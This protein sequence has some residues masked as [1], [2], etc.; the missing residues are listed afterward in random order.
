LPKVYIDARW[1]VRALSNLLVNAHK[2]TSDSSTITLRGYI[3]TTE[4]TLMLEVSDD[5]PGIPLESQPRLFDRFYRV[6]SIEQMVPGTGLGLAIVKSVADL[7]GGKIVVKSAPGEGSCFQMALPL[8][9]P[10]TT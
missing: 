9:V 8:A 2:Y 1:I 6:P 4:H 7:H 3:E 5:G 10:A